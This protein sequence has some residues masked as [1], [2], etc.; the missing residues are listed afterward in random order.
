ME[1]GLIRIARA[2]TINKVRYVINLH[3]SRLD[4]DAMIEPHFHPFGDMAVFLVKGTYTNI[5]GRAIDDQKR[6][7]EPVRICIG[8]GD[9]YVMS[10][11][12]CHDVEDQSSPTFSI[13]LHAKSNINPTKPQ[14]YDKIFPLSDEQK[15]YELNRLIEVYSDKDVF[16]CHLNPPVLKYA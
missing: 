14:D 16:Q 11:K 1:P 8:E 5:L 6:V 13:M 4:K 3:I 7:V 9:T 10:R 12:L 15:E 2:Y